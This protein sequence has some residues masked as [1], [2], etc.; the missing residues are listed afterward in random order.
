MGNAFSE[1]KDSAASLCDGCCSRQT[2][3]NGCR[4]WR[5]L[6]NRS[7]FSFCSYTWNEGCGPDTWFL[8]IFWWTS[9]LSLMWWVIFEFLQA[10]SGEGNDSSKFGAMATNSYYGAIVP[11][12]GLAVYS[13]FY[14][15]NDVS[16]RPFTGIMQLAA[17]LCVLAGLWV[18]A[19][20][21]QTNSLTTESTGWWL[22]V[23]GVLVYVAI[24]AI[25]FAMCPSI[26]RGF[27]PDAVVAPSTY[28]GAVVSV[29]VQ[30]VAKGTADI[31]V[32]SAPSTS[33]YT[34]TVPGLFVPG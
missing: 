29:P 15:I 25:L 34:R 33:R 19:Y 17:L 11:S 22:L 6:S 26:Q 16:R 27:Q 5:L 14:G 12:Y 1:P 2:C 23:F 20:G 4:C 9:L 21:R 10:W 8:P 30:A 7:P 13:F 32:E 3:C 28:Q 18:R 24:Y 31:G